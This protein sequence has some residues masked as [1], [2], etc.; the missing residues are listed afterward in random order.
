MW[1]EVSHFTSKPPGSSSILEGGDRYALTLSGS[2]SLATTYFFTRAEQLQ[3]SQY[4]DG[5]ANLSPDW[6][7][8]KIQ[9]KHNLRLKQYLDPALLIRIFTI[10]RK[11]RLDCV[12]FFWRGIEL[13]RLD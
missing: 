5:T 4:W 2:Q 13:D 3:Y 9:P 1:H 6:L 12:P 8:G 7:M 10:L 11:L